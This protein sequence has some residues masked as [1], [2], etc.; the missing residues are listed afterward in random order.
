MKAL[1]SV[2]YY[3]KYM[4]ICDRY[5]CNDNNDIGRLNGKR[6]AKGGGAGVHPTTLPPK[7]FLGVFYLFCYMLFYG[8]TD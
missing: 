8:Y 1:E 2:L 3:Y 6:W 4:M 7:K 5:G